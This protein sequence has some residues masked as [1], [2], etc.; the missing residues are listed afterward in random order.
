MDNPDRQFDHSASEQC[1][2]HK[3]DKPTDP[4][5]IGSCP[6]HTTDRTID[7]SDSDRSP[8]HTIDID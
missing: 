6:N 8:L 7:H 5:M 3:A 2:Q 4:M 1:R